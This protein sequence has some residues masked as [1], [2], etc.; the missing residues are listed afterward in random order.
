MVDTTWQ[1]SHEFQSIDNKLRRIFS[2]SL[3]L[4]LLYQDSA[5]YRAALEGWQNIITTYHM[6]RLTVQLQDRSLT[7]WHLINE[8][9]CKRVK[10]GNPAGQPRTPI[11]T[12]MIACNCLIA[13]GK[14]DKLMSSFWGSVLKR[15]H[16]VYTYTERKIHIGPWLSKVLILGYFFLPFG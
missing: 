13:W 14:K 1:S 6:T 12:K 5:V 15:S 8:L 7:E 3:S 9:A 10:Q 16:L 11:N 2:S 4:T